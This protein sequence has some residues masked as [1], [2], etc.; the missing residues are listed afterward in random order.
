MESMKR[1]IAC[2]VVSQIPLIT[3]MIYPLFFILQIHIIFWLVPTAF[4]GEITTCQSG[5]NLTDY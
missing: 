2:E 1:V 3:G 4:P 5:R